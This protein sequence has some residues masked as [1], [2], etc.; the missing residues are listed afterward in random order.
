[1]EIRVKAYSYDFINDEELLIKDGVA[2]LFNDNHLS[3]AEDLDDDDV[4]HEIKWDEDGVSLVRT[5]VS[6]SSTYLKLNEYKDSVVNSIYGELKFDSYLRDFVKSDDLWM[7]EYML[8][9]SGDLITHV[10][11]TWE[12]SGIMEL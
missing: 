7:V 6:S 12:L 10:R 1:M 2:Y 8:F 4:R 11:V 3:Y 9:N 5:G